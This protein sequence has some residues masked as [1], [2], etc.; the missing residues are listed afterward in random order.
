MNVA[1]SGP[2]PIRRRERIIHIRSDLIQ[3]LE[4]G[5]GMNDKKKI[6]KVKKVKRAKAG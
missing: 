2:N 6:K 1:V 5:A 4:Q 3:F